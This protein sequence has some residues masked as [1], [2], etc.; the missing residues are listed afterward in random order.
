MRHINSSL[1]SSL[2]TW[3]LGLLLVAAACSSASNDRP[4]PPSVPT[5]GEPA[6]LPEPRTEV[7]GATWHS[8]IAVAGGLTADA[9]ASSRFDLYVP[10]TN[11]WEPGPALPVSLHHLG[12]ATSGDR[13]YVVGGY[14]TTA[15]GEWLPQ[16]AVYS[17]GPGEATWHAEP[18]LKAP[19]GS[20]GVAAVHGRLVVT[21]GVTG[22]VAASTETWAP[23][24]AAWRSGPDLKERRE[25]LAMATLGG[26]VYAIAGR[27]PDNLRSV[28]S[29][30]GREAAWRGEPS[31]NYARGGIAATTVGDKVCVAGGEEP[32]GTIGSVECLSGGRWQKVATMRVPRHGLAVAALDSK[33]HVIAGGPQPGLF[34]SGTHEVIEVG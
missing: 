32:Q 12:L 16:A 26:R 33:L 28:E 5:I 18:S 24:D 7:A 30:D 8:R 14:T 11:V 13:L 27:N 34:V 29:W 17:L 22:D 21:G 31:V 25:H 6:E 3:A 15:D 4:P 1:R 10:E 20:P 23:G 9:R 2:D 19:R